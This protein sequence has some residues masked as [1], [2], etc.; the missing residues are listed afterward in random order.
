MDRLLA[1]VV[2]RQKGLS[3]LVR[4]PTAGRARNL[5]ES[6]SRCEQEQNQRCSEAIYI[7]SPQTAARP[8]VAPLSNVSEQNSIDRILRQ[9]RAPLRR[10]GSADFAAH[11]ACSGRLVAIAISIDTF[12]DRTHRTCGSIS[13]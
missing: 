4:S 13:A 3:Y 1:I 11:S 10:P 5:F 8:I 2:L 9:N 12:E 6:R 7:N